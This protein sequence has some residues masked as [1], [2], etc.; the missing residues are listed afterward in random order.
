[1]LVLRSGFGQP[2]LVVVAVE[3]LGRYDMSVNGKPV[4][5][6]I[7]QRHEDADH[8]AAVVEIVVLLHLL[9][10]DNLAVCRRDNHAQSVVTLRE[11]TDGATEE[12]EHHGP[13]Y[14]EDDGENPER[15]LCLERLPE[16]HGDGDEDKGAID[17]GV[18]A[19]TV[20]AYLLYAFQFLYSLSH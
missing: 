5:V 3:M 8:D 19:F 6:D 16:N 14:A 2:C 11:L 20:Y 7:E 15:E 17:Q 4:G 13:H 10:D 18:C 12:I 9:Y 1:M